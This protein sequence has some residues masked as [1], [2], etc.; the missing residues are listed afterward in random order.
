MALMMQSGLG[1]VP[2]QAGDSFIASGVAY[3]IAALYVPGLTTRYQQRTILLAGLSI[4]ITGLLILI[5]ML[6]ILGSHTGML[7]LS[8]ATSTICTGQAFIV[9][10]FYRIGIRN[11]PAGDA[12]AGSA[13]LSTILQASMGIGPVLPGGV[14]LY[15]LAGK[16]GNYPQAMTGFLTVEI[17]MMLTLMVVTLFYRRT[18]VAVPG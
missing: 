8:I 9:N 12:G 13:I 15:F 17:I 2:Q 7:A 18:V 3:F 11:I 16:H 10:S 4:Q 5:I 6:H 14:F 1:M